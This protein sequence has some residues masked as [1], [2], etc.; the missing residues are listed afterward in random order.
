MMSL[1]RA[2][3][4]A[5]LLVFSVASPAQA[6]APA[7]KDAKAA[8]PKA[9]TKAKLEKWATGLSGPHGLAQDAEGRVYV[10]ESGANK[11]T[12]FSRDGKNPEAFAEGLKSPAF[13]LFSDGTLY[14]SERKGDS[15]ARI[16]AK[17]Q[18]ERLKGEVTDPLGLALDP[19]EK[20]RLLAVSHQRSL[21]M[22]FAPAAEG[23][24]A[25]QPEPVVSPAAGEEYGW[26]DL[27]AASDGTLYITDEEGGTVLRQS[28]GGKL[29]EWVKGLDSPAGLLLGANG[30]VYVTE[31]GKKGRL[32]RVGSDGKPT[33]VADGLGK[34]RD[35]LLLEDGSM[36]VTDRAGGTVWRVKP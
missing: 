22:R 20:G 26:R 27:A 29:E 21:V 23:K 34:A 33:L 30:E 1:T 2:C 13:A 7:K 5:A 25:L 8:A 15:V 32:S 3:A 17:G 12:R 11:V 35:V 36:L 18:V 10:V 9:G 14:V 28:P 16:P 19:K 24:L 6:Q 4:V 31:E